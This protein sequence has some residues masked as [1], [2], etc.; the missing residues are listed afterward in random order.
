MLHLH[1]LD[2]LGKR[3]EILQIIWKIFYQ[4]K[5]LLIKSFNFLVQSSPWYFPI[6]KLTN[7]FEKNISI[8]FQLAQKIY[9]NMS[10]KR[11]ASWQHDP[12]I[13]DKKL[14]ITLSHK[15]HMSYIYMDEKRITKSIISQWIE[16]LYTIVKITGKN[17]QIFKN[18]INRRAI[19]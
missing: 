2:S 12:R 15:P 14:M 6:H 1:Y 9:W 4:T 18:I 19:K 13:I 16:W 10:N 11:S 5:W 8:I 7:I 3:W 17:F